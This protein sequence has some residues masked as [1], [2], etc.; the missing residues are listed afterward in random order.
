MRTPGSLRVQ[1]LRRLLGPMTAVLVGGA[2][3][4]YDLATGPAIEAYDQDLVDVALALSER[5]G[6]SGGGYSFEL[7]RAAEQLLRTDEYDAIY[8]RVSSPDGEAIAGDLD[9]PLPPPR[10]LQ[11]RNGSVYDAQYQGRP[12]RAVML[13]AP[14]AGETCGVQVAETTVK[15]DRMLRRI[16][17]SIVV[18]LVLLVGITLLAVWSGVES[19][20]RPLF[21][22]STEIKA[23]S[24]DDLRRI[25]ER[26]APTE[27]L[28]LLAGLNSLFGKLEDAN[29]N[30][31]RFLSNAAH[32]L[33][34]PLAGLRAHLELALSRGDGELRRSDLAHAHAATI[35]TARLANQL[36]AL[37]RAEPGGWVADF[38]DLDIAGLLETSA[39]DWVH[40]ARDRGI[41]LGFEIQ[42]ARVRGDRLLIGE[43]LENLVSNAL[44]Y[45]PRGGLV[46][47][48]CGAEGDRSF[49]EVED[50]GPGIPAQERDRV[51]ERFYRVPGSAG[52]GSGLGLA[53]VEEIARAH[54]ATLSIA[55]GVDARG[56]RMRLEFRAV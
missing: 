7:P 9:L 37:A 2:A 54:G 21:R 53:I 1:L 25:E 14:C 11:R 6:S 24:P 51:S 36:L 49:V 43:A 4:A 55:G 29:R 39:D 30:Q 44:D 50:D 12:I 35:R 38:V 17:A 13:R 27:L 15:R 28:P 16:L 34:T 47:V 5:I 3:I 33:R 26:Q 8:Y 22:I 32:Q 31:R 45:V 20:L 42:P 52:T 10:A 41:D 23:R 19:G 48:R 40:R 18:P 56:C 46:T